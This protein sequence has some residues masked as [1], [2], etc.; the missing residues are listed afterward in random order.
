MFNCGQGIPPS[1]AFGC[2]PLSKKKI[3]HCVSVV[4]C[5]L[6]LKETRFVKGKSD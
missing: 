1:F 3:V 5:T 2:G 6:P 4:P